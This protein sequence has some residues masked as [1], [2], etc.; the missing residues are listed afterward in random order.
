MTVVIGKSQA[1]RNL[2]RDKGR[3]KF[4]A[5]ADSRVVRDERAVE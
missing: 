2:L 3:L 5:D 4:N 1:T